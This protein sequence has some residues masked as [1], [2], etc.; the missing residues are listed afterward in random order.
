MANG[1]HQLFI[2]IFATNQFLSN[3]HSIKVIMEP[4]ILL[5]QIVESVPKVLI[6]QNSLNF[7]FLD[8][9]G[10]SS[11]AYIFLTLSALV[12]YTNF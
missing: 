6:L 9:L 4:E 8:L 1:L 12:M 2:R 5:N 7:S 10:V 11:V 3:L